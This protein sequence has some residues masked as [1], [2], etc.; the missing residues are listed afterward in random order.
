MYFL[1]GAGL[2][3]CTDVGRFAAFSCPWPPSST[4]DKLLE[5]ERRSQGAHS[6]KGNCWVERVLSLRHTCRIR[7][8]PTFP[9]LTEA[10]SDLIKCQRP[11]L[12]RFTQLISLSMPSPPGSYNALPILNT[13]I[14]QLLRGKKPFILP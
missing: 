1:S 9:M 2:I 7:K 11:D 6:E 3:A 14:E 12:R 4:F 10:V 13:D 8:R 5:M